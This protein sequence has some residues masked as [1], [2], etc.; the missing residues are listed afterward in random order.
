[1]MKKISLLLLCVVL[2]ASCDKY[3]IVKGNGNVVTQAIDVRDFNGIFTN[4]P[5]EI[6]YTQGENYI[7]STI[8]EFLE[9]K[10]KSITEA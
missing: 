1:M 3:K 4:I 9:V 5:A 8:E 6:K 10:W 2:F 7:V